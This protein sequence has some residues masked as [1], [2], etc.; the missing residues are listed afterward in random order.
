MF[1]KDALLV[2]QEA[3][4][5]SSASHAI[6]VCEDTKEL[7]ALPSDFKLHNLEPYGLLRRRARGTM[8][9]AALD[10]FADYT[11]VHAED[12]ASI[13]I[14]QDEMSATA[15]LNLGTPESPGQADNKAKLQLKKTAA[16]AEL[17]AITNGQSFKQATV[18]EFL[19][20]W[21]ENVKCFNDAGPIDA[22]KAI[23][24]VRKLTI[25][26]MR[27]IESTEQQLSNT[28]SAFESV[29]ASSTE[30]LPTT[31]HFACQPFADLQDRCF[32]LR[33]GVQTGS[34]KPSITLRITKAEKHAEEM[35]QELAMLIETKFDGVEVPVLLGSYTRLE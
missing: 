7:A 31:I 27:K 34:D 30:P 28:R 21:P 24:A 17:T 9:T 10:A 25:E 33:L 15:V 3:Q 1:N 23:A 35:A 11:K 20:D 4:S 8:L 13:F 22:P 19:E 5:I 14:H 16:Y 18:A 6:A 32:V 12:G 29:T 26:A 2:L